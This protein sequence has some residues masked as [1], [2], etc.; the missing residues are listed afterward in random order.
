MK[1]RMKISL[2]SASFAISERKASA[3]TSRNSPGSA[4]RPRDK[5]RAPE[6]KTISPEKPPGTKRHKYVLAGEPRH[7][8]LELS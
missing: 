8:N 2:S 6:I 7:E 3:L 1:A 4:T 5:E